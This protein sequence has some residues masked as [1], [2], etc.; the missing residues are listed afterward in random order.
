VLR[1]P[2]A[3]LSVKGMGVG[4]VMRVMRVMRVL[5]VLR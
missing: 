1:I 4:R 5:R 3:L 2:A